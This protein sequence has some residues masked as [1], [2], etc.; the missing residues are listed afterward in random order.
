ML[1]ALSK[2]AKQPI[3]FDIRI[4]NADNTD[5]VLLIKGAPDQAGSV[6]LSGVIVLS[7]MEPIQIKNLTMRMSGKLMLNIPANSNTP[8]SA[9]HRFVR[10]EKNFFTH[11]W[12]DLDVDPYL[13]NL[14]SNASGPSAI[15]SR[16]STNIVAMQNK[17]RNRSK[18]NSSILSLGSYGSSKSG[19]SYKTLP[20]GNYEFPF[21]VILPGSLTES[22][23]GLD[24][25][26]VV[27]RLQATVERPKVSDLLC[28]KHL[29]VVRTLSPD[30]V[31]LSESTA[32]DNEWPKKVEYS[33]SIPAKAIAIGS[34]TPIDMSL[35]PVLK[36]L[37]L[38]PI[39][40]YLV[41]TIQCSAGHR[42]ASNT[43]RIITKVKVKDPIGHVKQ[44]K[45]RKRM[46]EQG[47]DEEQICAALEQSALASGA[48][49]QYQDRWQFETVLNIPPSLAKCCQDASIL[50]NI[51]VRHKIKF[52]IS[53][54]NPD[55]HISELRAS[56]PIQLFVSP[57]VAVNCRSQDTIERMLKN[58]GKTVPANPKHEDLSVSSA[59]QCEGSNGTPYSPV[60]SNS[61]TDSVLF[62]K[63][64]TD[65]E[66]QAGIL[67][68]NL[69]APLLVSELMTPPNYGKHVY[70]RLYYTDRSGTATPVSSSPATPDLLPRVDSLVNSVSELGQHDAQMPQLEV[71]QAS[72][73]STSRRSS[74][75]NDIFTFE[76]PTALRANSGSNLAGI[77]LMIPPRSASEVI[78]RD[79][80]F[81]EEPYAQSPSLKADWEINK[82]SRVPSYTKAMQSDVTGD[83]LPPSYP[84]GSAKLQPAMVS[85]EKPQTVRHR[86]YSNLAVPGTRQRSHSNLSR[87]SNN[88]NTSLNAMVS[89]M[90]QIRL[91]SF[92][93][94]GQ[95][96]TT[97]NKQ[98]AFN[99]TP[100]QGGQIPFE[101]MTTQPQNPDSPY[102]QSAEAFKITRSRENSIPQKT[103]SFNNFLDFFSRKEL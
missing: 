88:S 70:D 87:T 85:I 69:A 82:L 95:K 73:S 55:G 92:D 81:L 33:I 51:K 100:V 32:I 102:M 34:A 61:D 23:E 58:F 18:S 91:S 30:A 13:D 62:A 80:S 36:G 79:N 44:R 89:D 103:S 16:S 78:S 48:D 76:T 45:L 41:E 7:V 2:S 35:V 39:K 14:Y 56:L 59:T 40:I 8:D 96:S 25:A 74:P 24:N 1:S 99:M 26:A 77:G 86:S 72:S 94:M 65:V 67:Q 54:I 9:L 98:F 52:V 37:C 60:S 46:K 64:H 3:L 75:V 83:E 28:T 12:D 63:T 21:S 68:N 4:R 22:V 19:S 29:R 84:A 17:R 31:E 71:N 20:Q 47:M 6:L 50:T 49:S 5:N 38:G 53:L 15:A 66:A 97:V 10:V 11:I 57:F 93:S 101:S 27:Y 90:S 43:E 42:G